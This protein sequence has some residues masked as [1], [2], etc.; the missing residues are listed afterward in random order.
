M[1]LWIVVNKQKIICLF[2]FRKNK[3]YDAINKVKSILF[4]KINGNQ[5]K[6]NLK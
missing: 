2:I 4:S 3:R 5:F 6:L 1:D